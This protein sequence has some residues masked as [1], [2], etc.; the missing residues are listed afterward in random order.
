[1]VTTGEIFEKKNWQIETISFHA[2]N[3]FRILPP[4]H[5]HL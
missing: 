4:P 1:M 3:N 5:S 2:R